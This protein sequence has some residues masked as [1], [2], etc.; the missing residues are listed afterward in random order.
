MMDAQ[1]FFQSVGPRE[2]A[3]YVVILAVVIVVLVGLVQ[4]FYTVDARSEAV[5]LRFGKHIDT[6]PSGLHFKWPF[7]VDRAI[8]VP[9]DYVETAEFGFR[10]AQAG[11][12]TRYYEPTREDKGVSAMLTGDL[13]IGSVEWTVQYKI[14]DTEAYLFNVEDVRGTIRDVGESVMR[15][16]VGDRSVDEVITIG[17]ADLAREAIVAAQTQ[18]DEFGC[19]VELTKLNLQDVRPPDEVK[20]AF[21]AVNRARQKKEE[22]I[23]Q[24]RAERNRLV[25]A[26]RGEREQRIKE[27]EAYMDRKVREV[28]GETNAFLM[29][30]AAYQK[31][32][33][34]TRVRLY[35]ETMED[36]LRKSERKVFVDQAVRSFLPFLDLGTGKG[37]ER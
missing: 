16:L 5:V 36:I 18:L 31:A 32:E 34:E 8:I 37:G 19:G 21:D 7:G 20:E 11:K 29:Q 27:A 24:A 17:R 26:A 25:P 30:F 10:T 1:T 13:N 35:M 14:K 9:I 6:V 12:R 2:L 23:N 22:L 15:S 3:K 4:C 28:T 33:E